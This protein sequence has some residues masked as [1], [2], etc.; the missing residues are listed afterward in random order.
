MRVPH[1]VLL[2]STLVTTSVLSFMVTAELTGAGLAGGNPYGGV[3][4][5]TRPCTCSVGWLVEVGDP[6][7]ADVVF[8]PGASQIYRE[9]Q[10][11]TPGVWHVG[12]TGGPADCRIFEGKGCTSIGTNPQL[13]GMDGT[14]FPI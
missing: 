1:F 6:T 14:S 5:V 8:I 2:I 4:N 10:H 11:I 13:M 3:A 9:Y 12:L 7:P